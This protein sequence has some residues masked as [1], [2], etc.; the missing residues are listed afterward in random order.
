MPRQW[1]THAPRCCPLAETG[2]RP[3][4]ETNLPE[5]AQE[6]IKNADKG[7]VWG[8]GIRRCTTAKRA[9]GAPPSLMAVWQWQECIREASLHPMAHRAA[10]LDPKWRR[11][12]P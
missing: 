12:S 6:E 1:L 9:E 11:C 8:A 7:Q 10:A 2:D 5:A 4:L 3:G